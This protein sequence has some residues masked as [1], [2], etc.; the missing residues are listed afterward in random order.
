MLCV[1]ALI[2]LITITINCLL[3]TLV[4]DFLQMDHFFLYFQIE[5]PHLFIYQEVCSQ[6][7]NHFSKLK[8]D[9]SCSSSLPSYRPDSFFHGVLWLS[10]HWIF[11]CK[12]NKIAFVHPWVCINNR[13]QF[14][15]L[16]HLHHAINPLWRPEMGSGWPR[17]LSFPVYSL[18]R[19]ELRL[20]SCLM[21]SRV[22]A[23]QTSP[24]S[25]ETQGS[26]HLKTYPGQR[27]VISQGTAP[28][29]HV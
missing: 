21:D 29:L 15:K 17:A 5:L 24:A 14:T 11:S 18:Y 22:C 20:I 28:L 10:R 6:S 23:L 1:S 3:G 27:E 9:L 2:I 26:T 16:F 19:A 7:P 12:S 8:D 25:V 13:C 4:S